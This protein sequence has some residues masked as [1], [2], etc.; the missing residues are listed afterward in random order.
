MKVLQYFPILLILCCHTIEAQETDTL[1][2]P[3][4]IAKEKRL[5]DEDLKNKKEGVY[6]TGAPDL[7]SDPVNGFGYG[8][9]GSLFFNG[10]RTDP[11]FAYTPYRARIDLVLFN[12]TRSQREVMLKLDVPYIFNTK[13]RLRVEGG[14]EA[15][16]NHLY[17]GNTERSLNGL[18]YYTNNDSAKPIIR[19]AGYGDYEKSLTGVN[20]FYNN[21]FKKEGILNISMERSYLEGKFRILL[22]Y[23][24][25]Y[26]NFGTFAGNSLLRQDYDAGR[27]IG[28]QKGFV[29]I[30]QAG[31][32]YDTRDL[33]T[34]PGNGIFAELTNETSLKELGSLY[35]FNKTFAHFNFYKK[36]FPNTFKKMI[37]AGRVAF[38]YTALNAPF[39]EYQDEW[40]S[41]GSIEGLGGPN[42]LRGYKQSRFLSRAMSFNNLELRYR[43]AECNLLKQH[44]A[45]SAVPFVDAGA[46]WD[47]L[48][49]VSEFS[50]WRFS[51]GL[52]LRIAW[53]VNTILR[54][55]YAIS[56]EDRQFF[57]NLAHA[58]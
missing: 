42:T 56:K 19:N 14:Y 31:L 35:E 33:E 1:K 52:G 9:E 22:G 57:F 28:L 32:I 51:E 12:T 23:E 50:N 7:S 37:I 47:D 29:Q 18:S 16:P 53:N 43:F 27:V 4:A 20:R 49:R 55:D 17:F 30:L 2:L 58:F 41:E 44:F 21:Y 46:V 11:F 34:D 38:G 15:N 10:K 26:V 3:F 45:F 54:F 25:A 40:S 24:V 48:S 6:V 8:G 36:I 5:P 13:W 39:F